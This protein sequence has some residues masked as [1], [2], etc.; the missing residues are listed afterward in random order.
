MLPADVGVGL[1][2]SGLSH[3]VEVR[4]LRLRVEGDMEAQAIVNIILRCI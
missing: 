1:P 4:S 3:G 2:G